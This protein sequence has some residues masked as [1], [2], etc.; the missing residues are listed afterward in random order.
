MIRL[1]PCVR[2]DSIEIVREE[3]GQ[4]LDSLAGKKVE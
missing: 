3:I 1:R 2:R 4:L